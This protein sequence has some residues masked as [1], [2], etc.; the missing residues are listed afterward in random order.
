MRLMKVGAGDTAEQSIGNQGQ[1]HDMN[2]HFLDGIEE[3]D[4]HMDCHPGYG[5]PACPVMPEE[6]EETAYRRE[7]AKQGDPQVFPTKDL[8]GDELPDMNRSSENAGSYQQAGNAGD[9]KRAF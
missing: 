3:A 9:R 4:G 7:K 8:P 6:D 1:Q 5:K 2:R